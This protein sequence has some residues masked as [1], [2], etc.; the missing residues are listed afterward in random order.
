MRGWTL[1][2][3]GLVM[4]SA[5]CAS[6]AD[7]PVFA[8]ISFNQLFDKH[9]Q[10]RL[11]WTS[12][13]FPTGL[14][15]HQRL[16]AR[17]EIEIDGSEVAR[18][19][20]K[21]QVLMLVQMEDSDGVVY[22]VHSNAPLDGFDRR[23]RADNVTYLQDAFVKPGDYQV[24][25]AVIVTGTGEHAATQ[26]SLHIDPV[27]RDP[28]PETWNK[29]PAVEFVPTLDSPEAWF[30]PDIS[31]TP[32]IRVKT[33][34]PLH[35]EVIGIQPSRE[36]VRFASQTIDRSMRAL[37]PSL[38]VISSLQL[39]GGSIDVSLL[40]VE[41]RR[42]SFEQTGVTE[43][44]WP[45]L[46]SVLSETSPHKIDLRDLQNRRGNAQF[47]VDEIRRRIA[48]SQD[49]RGVCALMILG[50]P[51]S[52]RGDVDLSPISGARS[53]CR[54]FYVRFYTPVEQVEFSEP[55][56]IISDAV[57][58]LLKPVEP[59]VFDVYN[60]E[61]FRRTLAAILEELEKPAS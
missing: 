5:A 40:D 58:A 28:F 1:A 13:V 56:L 32:G 12:R 33:L 29:M 4:F 47:L 23:F 61:Q 42:V 43:L 50:R 18:H 38:K 31:A 39:P 21:G 59:R 7:D 15:Y 17:V 41:R 24:S 30:L 37:V 46:R 26:Q 20:G 14:S 55:R 35:L 25:M 8:D 27:S 44:D 49:D 6:A 57:A 10:T 45:R 48:A 54:V 2:A 3:L 60:A 19:A 36:E 9:G 51:M 52:F 11:R 22:R 34:R 53:G 16:R